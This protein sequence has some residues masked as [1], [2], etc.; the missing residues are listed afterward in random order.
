M[1]AVRW[2]VL[3][4]TVLVAS[5]GAPD[6][7]L[8]VDSYVTDVCAEHYQ[9]DISIC[10]IPGWHLVE[11]GLVFFAVVVAAIVSVTAATLLAPAA[12][13]A[14]AIVCA[15]TSALFAAHSSWLRLQVSWQQLLA[16]VG[17]FALS[18]FFLR[19]ARL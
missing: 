3:A 9:L 8:C 2:I 7:F 10:P 6:L 12:R 19:Y 13:R 11:A 17:A 4:A 18:L 14:A 16:A 15:A 1:H 5:V